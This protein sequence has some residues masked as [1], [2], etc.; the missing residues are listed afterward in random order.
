MTTEHN[1]VEHLKKQL[2]QFADDLEVLHDGYE[3]L[4]VVCVGSFAD[5]VHV[6]RIINCLNQQFENLLSEL[7]RFRS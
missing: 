2:F 1:E 7:S 5:A 6:G 3:S 4:Q